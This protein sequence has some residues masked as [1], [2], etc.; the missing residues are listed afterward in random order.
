MLD[1]RIAAGAAV[2]TRADRVNRALHKLWLRIATLSLVSEERIGLHHLVCVMCAD[3]TVL[4]KS[5]AYAPA[6]ISLANKWLDRT[7]PASFRI[8]SASESG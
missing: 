2:S 6:K 7:K 8:L 5:V 3:R 1:N 4:K